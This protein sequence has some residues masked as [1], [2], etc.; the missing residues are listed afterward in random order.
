MKNIKRVLSFV[1]ILIIIFSSALLPSK[2]AEGDY[3]FYLE[4]EDSIIWRLFSDQLL[5]DTVNGA[6]YIYCRRW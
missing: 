5:Y 6:E 1:M 4:L 2:A 3:D